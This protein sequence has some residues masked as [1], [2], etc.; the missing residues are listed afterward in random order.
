MKIRWDDVN[1]HR[2]YLSPL[3]TWYII[4]TCHY[5]ELSD[6]EG[7]DPYKHALLLNKVVHERNIAISIYFSALS[8][9]HINWAWRKHAFQNS[10][11]FD[12]IDEHRKFPY[13]LYSPPFYTT[14]N[15]VLIKK[16]RLPTREILSFYQ[17]RS[18]MVMQNCRSKE[19]K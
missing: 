12:C 6:E 9:A 3:I 15:M 10:C 18:G 4:L 2:I 8:L 19:K 16:I 11:I 17:P 1:W 14:M 5:V 13:K 7:I